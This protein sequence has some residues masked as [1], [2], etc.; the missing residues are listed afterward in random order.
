M[1]KLGGDVRSGGGHLSGGV[2]T[3]GS[4]GGNVSGGGGDAKYRRS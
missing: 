2:D 3:S 1:G 4:E